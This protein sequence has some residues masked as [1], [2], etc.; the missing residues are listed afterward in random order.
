MMSVIL[1]VVSPF[2]CSIQPSV[3]PR[4][5]VAEY[6]TVTRSFQS[7]R[8]FAASISDCRDRSLPA[9]VTTSRNSRAWPQPVRLKLLSGTS[10]PYFGRLSRQSLM[11]TLSALAGSS[12]LG[13]Q[14]T[15][16]EPCCSSFASLRTDGSLTTAL[17]SH[18]GLKPILPDSFII[19]AN[20][21]GTAQVSTASAP[22]C[23]IFSACAL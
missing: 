18:V 5:S 22:D 4:R 20:G 6:E 9:R 21:A 3:T 17:L 8:L 10:G 11:A 7:L 14:A 19:D 2:N 23:C 12:G 16:Y 13:S 1:T 15:K